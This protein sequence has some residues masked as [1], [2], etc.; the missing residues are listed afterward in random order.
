MI[1]LEMIGY[2][3]DRAGSQHYP[4]PFMNRV[5]P[6]TGNFIA[7]VGNIRSRALTKSVAEE[8]R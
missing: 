2:F 8:F 6:G 1:C 3:S 4:F 7:M 5:Y